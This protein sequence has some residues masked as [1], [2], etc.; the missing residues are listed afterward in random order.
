MTQWR[1]GDELAWRVGLSLVLF[2]LLYL[3]YLFGWLQP[4]PGPIRQAAPPTQAGDAP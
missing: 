2:G 4:G 1:L 3:S